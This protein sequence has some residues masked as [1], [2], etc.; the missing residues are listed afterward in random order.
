MKSLRALL[1]TAPSI[2]VMTM[3]MGTI[4][5]ITSLFD[6]TGRRQH[7]LAQVW[8]RLLLKIGRVRTEAEGV[9]KLDPARPYVLAANHCSYMDTPLV[10]GSIPLDFR[11]FAKQGLFLIPLLGTH[12]KRAGHIP[13]IRDNPRAA[14]KALSDGARLIRERK[15][16]VLLFP[17]GGRSERGL[18]EFKEGAAYVAIK[19]GIPIVPLGIVG[20]REVLPMHSWNVRPGT[21]RLLVGDP[22]ETSG[23][24]LHDRAA[25]T[26]T[27]RDKI[28]ELIGEAVP[29]A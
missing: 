3:V 8:S 15:I 12:L 22:I 7:R 4:S 19:A 16:S 28:A 13:V 20:T 5:L 6:A 25:L 29:V 1:I 11:F 26:Q 10:L 27:V 2:I 17:E 23:M 14:I 21:A 18:R 9:G 24:G